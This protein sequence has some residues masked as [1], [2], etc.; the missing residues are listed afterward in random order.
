MSENRG[1]TR[2]ALDAYC[3]SKHVGLAWGRTAILADAIDTLRARVDALEPQQPPASAGDSDPS[4]AA[5]TSQELMNWMT[6][7]GATSYS[8]AVFKRIE[9]GLRIKGLLAND[10]E[11]DDGGE[12][13]D[14]E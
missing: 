11:V 14:D 8:R 12:G 3:K 2:R 10:I 6:N 13:D 1:E 5:V 4:E 9:S 7:F